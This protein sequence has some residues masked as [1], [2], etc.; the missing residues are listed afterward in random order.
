MNG[1]VTEGVKAGPK[2]E[3]YRFSSLEESDGIEAWRDHFTGLR[4]AINRLI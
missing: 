2:T 1:S 3:G 4:S